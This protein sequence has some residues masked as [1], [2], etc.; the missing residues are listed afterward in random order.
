MAANERWLPF[1]RWAAELNTS[2]TVCEHA[3]ERM[4]DP[5]IHSLTPSRSH[6]RTHARTHS[7]PH[8]IS[9]VQVKDYQQTGDETDYLNEIRPVQLS[10]ITGRG[11]AILY[12][13]PR[14]DASP[15]RLKSEAANGLSG[16]M[17]SLTRSGTGPSKI[18]P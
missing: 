9:K 6:A 4:H 17:P 2:R 1:R 11:R 15:D 5:F 16:Q 3:H 10:L 18:P 14:R 8:F 12:R 7:P 13:Q